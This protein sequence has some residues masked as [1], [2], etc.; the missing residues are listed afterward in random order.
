MPF[1]ALLLNYLITFLIT[2]LLRPK[3]NVENAKPA[4]L[5]DFNVPTA[6]EGRVVPIIWGKIKLEG[7]NI[8]WYG[9]LVA[10]PVTRKVKTGLF[11]ST[12]QTTGYR[13]KIGLQFALCRGPLNG[14]DDFLHHIR[15]DDNYAWG[16]EA[17]TADP[18]LAPTDAGAIGNIN[19]PEFF[20]GKDAGGGGGLIG[21]FRVYSGSET[22]LID[23]YLTPFQ[24]PQP[25]YRGTAFISW[26]QG[27]IGS[28]P[29][30]RPFAFE[31]SRFPDGLD[32]RSFQPG[33]EIVGLGVNPMNVV[34]EVLNNDEWGLAISATSINVL[35]LRS[36]AAV[37]ATEGQGFSWIWDRVLNVLEVI[38][39]VEEQV[40]G[41]LFQDPVSG[42]FDFQLIRDDYT[43]GI[44]PLLDESNV[45][46]I[47]KF[48]RPSWASTSNVV[49]VNFNSRDKN[50]AV[51][52]ALAQDMANVDINQAVNAVE[53]KMPGVKTPALAN[54]IAWRELRLLSFPLA[55]GAL[56]SDRSQFDLKP[57]DVRELT[58][59]LL[60]LIRLPI[61]ITKVNRGSIL[62]GKIKIDFTQDIF[63][64]DT[65][66]FAD[67]T[68][69]L[70]IPPSDAALAA[71]AEILLE[72]PFV[73]T[74]INDTGLNT[75]L[76]Q[77]GDIV[78]QTGS[79][80]T[81]DFNIFA[82]TA[83]APG[84]APVPTEADTIPPGS[85]GEFSPFGLLL[86]ALDRG[87]TNGF[88]DAVG[89]TIDS[90]IDLDKV[91][92]A[93][94][95][96]LES[97]QNLLLIDDELILF[98]TVV[99]NFNQTFIIRDLL[100]GS[101]DTIPA[102]HADDSQVFIFSYGIGLVN[103]VPFE[104]RTLN[105]QVRNQTKTPFA[106]FPFASTIAI[107]I[108]TTG[109]AAFGYPPRD[110]QINPGTPGGGTFPID[111]GS[112][113][114]AE[115]VGTFAIRWHGSD[116]FT[117]ARATAWDDPH[118]AE[119]NG[120]GFHLRIIQDPLGIPLVVLDV[121][122]IP[123]GATEGAYNA[124]GFADDTV[125]D[126][127]QF[128][129]SA[130]NVFGESQIWSVGPFAIYGMGY[131]FDEKFGGDTAGVIL[132]KGDPPAGIV[133]VPGVSVESIFRLTASGTFDVDDDL[134]V[135]IT[136]LSL[137]D[138]VG[139]NENYIINGG[140]G[141]KTK[142]SDWLIELRDLIAADFDPVKVS[143]SVVGDVL[144][145]SSFFGS[146]GGTIQNNSAAS[147]A[148]II[149]ER[150]SILN[151]KPQ[152]IHFDLYQADESVSPAIVSLAPDIAA[153]YN[154]AVDRSNKLDLA[155]I[156]LTASARASIDA[157]G[158]NS[159]ALSWGGREV[160]PGTQAISRDKPLRDGTVTLG[161][162]AASDLLSQ[163]RELAS[164]EWSEYIVRVDWTNY[165]PIPG[166]G[167]PFFGQPQDRVGVEVIMK[168]EFSLVAPEFWET[169]PDNTIYQGGFGPIRLLGKQLFKPAVFSKEGR[170]QAIRV[171]FVTEYRDSS[172]PISPV[173]LG[174]VYTIELDGALFQ[175]TAIAADVNDGPYRDGIY[176]ALTALINA[177]GNFTVVKTNTQ[178]REIV[179]ATFITSIEIERDVA[180]IAFTFDARAS[181][182]LEILVESFT[183]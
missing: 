91:R 40:D 54:E 95:I 123:A 5:G 26:Q 46:A 23:D 7:P 55:T 99:D 127:Y 80:L 175:Y 121:G 139:Q 11:S 126:Q 138:T 144:T 12:R 178:A 183:Q 180:N 4:G 156:G 148:D 79:S 101:L 125:S 92:N 179:G 124:Q 8:V 98:S 87:E 102:P 157:G 162:P 59:S 42:D 16:V 154:S 83:D 60:G 158:I 69:T 163:L 38:R 118:V 19:Q 151:G 97:L 66:S 134:H 109:R 159:V 145:V 105:V 143:A 176:T 35:N 14:P 65:A 174:Q 153:T 25:A 168:Q 106:V 56:V 32:L 113:S 172:S 142:V 84:P 165:S 89:F 9:D 149:E 70:W 3:P 133:P 135:R 181:H 169:A 110:V 30:L 21:T 96:E 57:G 53:L 27:E 81:V 136:F 72:L 41:V 120:V 146:L 51:S 88:Q 130:T 76:L 39:T 33:D 43:P 74:N 161:L 116:K 62:D 71:F 111:A 108:T 147:R 15:V 29:S 36:I 100:R 128:E 129:L 64:A 132:I 171:S 1:G 44:Q 28:S 61:R 86:G 75:T 114:G 155:I 117:Q 167:N 63:T 48:M 90:P 13:Y 24:S 107:G 150:S 141:G 2:E 112:P 47:T 73:L 45:E 77:V 17:S 82:T 31:L 94:A 115:L 173:A 20:G 78:V 37:L 140:L 177:S 152:I 6:T 119:E 93:D 182:G 67:P 52:F 122:G 166:A 104:D 131:K 58:W 34:F 137:G 50:Y 10:I 22:Q 160:A 18:P 170:H 49:N 164:N 68:D 85:G 103:D